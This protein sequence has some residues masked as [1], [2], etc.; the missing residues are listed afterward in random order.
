MNN[1]KRIVL[2]VLLFWLVIFISAN[3]VFTT[4]KIRAA[5]EL[6]NVEVQ[7]YEPVFGIRDLDKDCNHLEWKKIDSSYA[8]LRGNGNI[9]LFGE[10]SEVYVFIDQTVLNDTESD[11]NLLTRE[12]VVDLL[13]KICEG[14][15]EQ[16]DIEFSRESD[17]ALT[18][19]ED[20]KLFV[21]GK[22][23][24]YIY[25]RR[26]HAYTTV[27]NT[28]LKEVW[29]EFEH[30]PYYAVVWC[31]VF[32]TMFSALIV[33]IGITISRKTG[34][35]LPLCMILAIPTVIAVAYI[36]YLACIGYFGPI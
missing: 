36:V 15:M 5:Y 32:A 24:G 18:K 13:C 29:S 25:L 34:K 31:L 2:F 19:Y 30:F 22:Y 20:V 26:G 27:N 7:L 10:D 23:E 8:Y 6:P 1:T 16:C 11:G 4:K 9:W 28:N 3:L 35:M 33:L 12:E 21:S 14:D 17:D